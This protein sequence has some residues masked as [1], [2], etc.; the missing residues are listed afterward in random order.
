MVDPLTLIL[1]ALSVS[2]FAD[3]AA[4]DAYQVLKAL[5]QRKFADKAQLELALTEYIKD[6]V[7]WEKPL[8]KALTEVQADKD[9]EVLTT[10]RTVLDLVDLGRSTSLDQPG[11]LGPDPGA[12]SE[13]QTIQG[14]RYF[15]DQIPIDQASEEHLPAKESEPEPQKRWINAEFQDHDWTKPLKLTEVYTLAFDV[16]IMPRDTAG[17][18]PLDESRLFEEGE[19]Q[20]VLIVRLSS[21]DFTI[22]TKEP[23]RLFVPRTGK[24]KNKA[25][26]D[27]EPRS[28][29]IGEIT[30]TFYRDNNFIQSIT[31]KVAVEDPRGKAII[32]VESLG[33]AVEGAFAVRPRDVSLFIRNTGTGFA[34]EIVGTVFA[35]GT[36]PLTLPQLNKMID[37][38]RKDLH[39]LV[40][41]TFKPYN[42]PVY[43]T[44]IDIPTEVNQQA[45]QRLARSGFDL[46]Q[47][48]F[49][50][51]DADAQTILLGDRLRELI[52]G[53]TLN[54]QIASKQF[55]LP[56]GLMYM[57]DKYDAN[58]ID[59]EMFL[60]LKHIIE[61]IPL[62]QNMKVLDHKFSAILAC[63]SVSM[64]TLT[65]IDK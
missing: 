52:H 27:I 55:L 59:P 60:G 12:V 11:L 17:F 44:G 37:K 43:Q 45:L 10:A 53:E 35:E 56:W 31:L 61:Q 63:M 50:G 19:K 36:L 49:Y 20:V 22:Y 34:I 41:M 51:E 3:K 26:F 21:R 32:S 62:Q 57:V 28:R 30:A 40:H 48:I 24:S 16:G 46:Y 6:P 9:E 2:P 29:G 8:K 23:Q 1:T 18:V 7:T 42:T 14:H 15:E 54:I 25:R 38:V 5:L 64:S 65:S 13:D 47:G 4:R 58:H 39:D 33:R